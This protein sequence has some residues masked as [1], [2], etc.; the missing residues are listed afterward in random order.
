MGNFLV[1]PRQGENS[2][3]CWLQVPF[4]PRSHLFGSS[5]TNL[6]AANLIAEGKSLA[7]LE[8]LQQS[9]DVISSPDQALDV[10]DFE[11]AARKALP[12][13]TSV[14][15][16]PEWTRTARYERIEKAIRVYRFVRAGSSMS[17]R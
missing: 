9:D 13:P 12:P 6:L 14:T 3:G 17:R 15:W 10:M 1:S 2:C 16:P 5:L 11:P 4:S 8:I 7:D